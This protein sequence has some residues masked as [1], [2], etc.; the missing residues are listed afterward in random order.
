MVLLGRAGRLEGA[1]WEVQDPSP[2]NDLVT[3]GK[4]KGILG[5]FRGTEQ[6]STLAFITRG[7]G[8]TKIVFTPQEEAAE[9]FPMSELSPRT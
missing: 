5:F 4:G 2:E 6:E 7:I 3:L 8:H 1:R 9:I